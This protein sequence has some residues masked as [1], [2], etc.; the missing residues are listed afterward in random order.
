MP[1]LRIAISTN[2]AQRSITQLQKDLGVLGSSAL[3]NEQDF[4][5]LESRLK[6]GMQADKAKTAIDNLK[7][8]I[9]LTRLE[10]AKLQTSIGDYTGSVKTLTSGITDACSRILNLNSALIGLAGG[11]SLSR[12]ASSAIETAA[13][14]EQMEMKLEALTKGRGKETLAEINDWAKNMPVNTEKAVNAFVSMQ[15]MGLKPTIDKMETLTNVAIIF[16]EDALPRVSRALGQ[17]QTLGKLSAEELNQLSEVGINARKYLTEAFGMTVDEIQKSGIAIEEVIDTIWK[18]FDADYNGA[19]KSAMKSWQGVTSAFESSVTEIERTIM[20]A[21]VFDELKTQ[22]HNVTD[23]MNDWLK[24]NREL[25]RQKVPEVIRDIKDG[26]ND[27]VSIY[28]SLPDEVVGAAGFGLLGRMLL[29]PNGMWIGMAIYGIKDMSDRVSTISKG[30]ELSGRG[31]IDWDAFIQG[32]REAREEMVAIGEAK[33][34]LNADGSLSFKIDTSD[35]DALN[36][37]TQNVGKKTRK[38]TTVE[39]AAIKERLA[40]YEDFV[41]AHHE[42]TTDWYEYEKDKLFEQAN[43]WEAY[44]FDAVKV[45]EWLTAEVIALAEKRK[46]EVASEQKAKSAAIDKSL[47]DFF[48]EIDAQESAI[49]KQLENDEK[50]QQKAADKREQQQQRMWENIQDDSADILYDM[51]D[52]YE[53]AWENLGDTIVDIFKRTISEM[54]A[55]AIMRP[56]IV[57]VVQSMGDIMGMDSYGTTA[58][59]AGSTDITGLASSGMSVYNAAGLMGTS[60]AYAGGSYMSALMGSQVGTLPTG[61]GTMLAA[62]G[63]SAGTMW[64]AGGSL[65]GV[66]Y[67]SLAGAGIIGPLGYSTIGSALGLPQSEYSGLTAGLGS[68]GGF[69]LGTQ[70]GAFGG[71]I[72]LALGALAGGALGGLMGDG[73]PDDTDLHLLFGDTSYQ[74]AG[75]NDFDSFSG[76]WHDE[77]TAGDKITGD[78]VVANIRKGDF[79]SDDDAIEIEQQFVD[80]FDA[81][82][83]SLGLTLSEIVGNDGLSIHLSDFNEMLDEQGIEATISEIADIFWKH[84]TGTISDALLGEGAGDLFNTE[85]VKNHF[86]SKASEAGL[87]Y[88][89]IFSDYMD[90]LSI[91]PN[92]V[93]LLNKRVTEEEMSMTEAIDDLY[94]DIEYASGVIAPALD[95][96]LAAGIEDASFDSFKDAFIENLTGQMQAIVL[97]TAATSFQSSLFEQAFDQIGGLDGIF[98]SFFNDDDYGREDLEAD[99]NS[100]MEALRLGLETLEP[101][102]RELTEIVEDFGLTAVDVADDIN[103]LQLSYKTTIGDTLTGAEILSE[104]SIENDDLATSLDEINDEASSL[105]AA[106]DILISEMEAGNISAENGAGIWS[107]MTS[108]YSSATAAAEQYAEAQLSVAEALQGGLTAGQMFTEWGINNAEAA[109]LMADITKDG[110]TQE[111]LESAIDNFSALGLEGEELNSVISYLATTFTDAATSIESALDSINDALSELPTTENLAKTELDTFLDEL[112][113]FLTLPTLEEATDPGYEYGYITDYTDVLD[114]DG[115]YNALKNAT[116]SIV[117]DMSMT[118]NNASDDPDN[119][120][121][122]ESDVDAIVTDIYA[123]I[124][125]DDGILPKGDENYS[126]SYIDEEGFN[127]WKDAILAGTNYPTA[128][129]FSEAFYD[130]VGS[131][132]NLPDTIDDL[133]VIARAVGATNDVSEDDF[134][135]S[136]PYTYYGRIEGSGE[137][138]L[139]SESEISDA[140]DILSSF[141]GTTDYQGFIDAIGAMDNDVLYDIYGEDVDSRISS[142]GSAYSN[143]LDAS[144][145]SS[146]AS[147]AT[148]DQIQSIMDQVQDGI[149][150]IGLSDIEAEL[151]DIAKQQEEWIASL[152]DLNAATD[153]NIGLIDEWATA[154]KENSFKNFIEDIDSDFSNL[155]TSEFEQTVDGIFTIYQGYID[156]LGEYLLY[157]AITQSEYDEATQKIKALFNDQIEQI[158]EEMEQSIV[159]GFIAF[160]TAMDEAYNAPGNAILKIQNM[161]AD[162]YP[163][164]AQ[165]IDNLNNAILST[166]DS[167]LDF[168]SSIIAYGS[169]FDMLNESFANGS[170]SADQYNSVLSTAT[171]LYTKSIA[172]IKDQKSDWESFTDSITDWLDDLEPATDLLDQSYDTAKRNFLDTFQAAMD[173][174]QD[175]MDGLT[176]AADDFLTASESYNTSSVD[177]MRDYGLIRRYMEDAADVGEKQV[178]SVDEML[179]TAQDQ[180]VELEDLKDVTAESLSDLYNVE[181]TI[182]DIVD[183]LPDNDFMASIF[184]QY[185][186]NGSPL[187][188]LISNLN[189][190]VETSVA[191]D[192]NEVAGKTSDSQN[193]LMQD[194]GGQEDKSWYLSDAGHVYG[195]ENGT[196]DELRENNRAT[197]FTEI[198]DYA[199]YQST[200]VLSDSLVGEYYDPLERSE[201]LSDLSTSDAERLA[202]KLSDAS[203]YEFEVGDDNSLHGYVDGNERYIV[204]SGFTLETLLDQ[205]NIDSFSGGGLS[206]GPESGYL[207]MLHGNEYVFPASNVTP[208]QPDNSNNEELVEEI[209]Q[210]RQELKAA[211]VEVIKAAKKTAKKLEKFDIDGMPAERAA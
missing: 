68:A 80:Y 144:E 110:I 160:N 211:N 64:G 83:D 63:T 167:T 87:T 207:A 40:A 180:I 175:A 196:L 119:W 44:G 159:E 142:L 54:A 93:E 115:Y 121:G 1:G 7:K 157:D 60:G 164:I 201:Y 118:W 76:N 162:D 209:R 10:T 140:L 129:D 185:L 77:F 184:D 75:K 127:F 210:L 81:V 174:D 117:R 102:F 106:L 8:S 61:V 151:Y 21:G 53:N 28:K 179:S 30:L 70:I 16:G 126:I 22:I 120:W 170:I 152:E 103:S 13:S 156:D 11:Y 82:A 2:E 139:S 104:Y 171:D 59:T 114:E 56:I 130:A 47:N 109:R 108:L 155:D 99:F 197:G 161:S 193:D 150:R 24:V 12:I 181:S 153:E 101:E 29:G 35:L 194:Y 36:E 187:A 25:I 112:D 173:G 84:Y 89:D 85:E 74:H 33:A 123:S 128:E 73:E 34:T 91:L 18:G 62:D 95:V 111:E 113:F 42:A 145:S 65:G 198:T 177:Y 132:S 52:D 72:G 69:Y 146:G 17:M 19:A 86:E 182:A 190:A 97:E 191:D 122:S 78:G 136:E 38:L 20:A 183:F 137:P 186:G 27:I 94:N 100:S 98:D 204:P 66:S 195:I 178:D 205:F 172:D 192:Y 199:R 9:N 51:L 14:F 79:I 15:A 41:D 148:D 149:D 134:T 46:K 57:P 147:D 165:G 188:Q 31:L 143:Y 45:E 49:K 135:I 124:G 138:I 39:K 116:S 58:T 189:T 169:V 92:A 154:Q 206:V 200:G 71:P 168:T 90:T 6:S 131:E 23:E 133:L 48:R 105:S 203:K 163:V 208:L 96:G 88:G 50:A 125:R 202:N 26:I 166:E 5:K 176:S 37:K 32:S 43:A 55:E 141:D 4:K 107:E 67:G 3:E 158:F